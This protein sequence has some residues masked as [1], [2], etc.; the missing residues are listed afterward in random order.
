MQDIDIEFISPSQTRAITT[1]SEREQQRRA[2]QGRF[3]RP[4]KLGEGPNGRIAFV[5][6]E[7]QQWN[8]KRLAER[9]RGEAA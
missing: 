6:A 2:K 9:D 5:K 1:L 7:V 3:P 8:A 4:V